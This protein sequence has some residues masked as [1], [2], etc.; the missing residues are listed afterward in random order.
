MHVSGAKT[1]RAQLRRTIAAL[2]P[3]DVLMVT[4]LDRLARSTRD[5]LNTLAAITDRKAGFRPLRDAWAD[6]TTSHGRLMLTVLGGLAEFEHDLRT[7]EGRERAKG[8]GVKM[9]RKPKLTPHQQRE[10]IKRRDVDGEPIRDVARTYFGIQAKKGKLDASGV[11][12]SNVAEILNQ[13]SMMLGHEIFD[14]EIG[15]RVLV[16]HAFIVSVGQI[17]KAARNWLGNKLDAT[18]RSQILFMDR[19]DILNLFVV[20]NMPLPPK[21]LPSPP[22][23]E[24]DEEI[25]F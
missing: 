13:V 19:D 24:L 20:T 6:T 1:D 15:K 9:G 3:G 21:A 22:R 7:A 18:K 14:P 12:T 8:R 16:D 17:T 10:A 23:A 2:Q 11:S 25:P 4:R 5:L